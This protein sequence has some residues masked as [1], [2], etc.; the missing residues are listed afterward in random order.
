MQA[1]VLGLCPR[2]RHLHSHLEICE[3]RTNASTRCAQVK[4]NFPFLRLRQVTSILVFIDLASASTLASASAG[5]MSNHTAGCT[6]KSLQFN[7]RWG[8]TIEDLHCTAPKSVKQNSFQLDASHRN[9]S[10]RPNQRES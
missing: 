5:Y 3:A 7:F 6:T 1:T 10:W 9:E 4:G 8:R 2:L